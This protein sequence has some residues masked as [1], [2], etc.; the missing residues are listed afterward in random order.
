MWKANK[1]IYL[2][3][4]Q[5]MAF[6]VPVFTKLMNTQ[7]GFADISYSKILCKS[8][9]KCRK[10]RQNFN[11]APEEN[12]AFTAPSFI[13]FV[14]VQGH[15]CGSHALNCPQTNRGICKVQVQIHVPK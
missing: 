8:D 6:T 5:S 10:Y 13:E 9:K 15:F 3:P 14:S 7:C 4:T 2:C 11:Y 12:M 1:E